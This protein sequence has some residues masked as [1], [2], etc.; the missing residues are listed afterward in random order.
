[1]IGWG[2]RKEA[3][4]VG[5]KIATVLATAGIL[6]F[7]SLSVRAEDEKN[8]ALAKALSEATVSL[9]E[10]LEAS[11]REGRP[12]SAKYEIENGA[13]QLSVYVAK[14]N[15]FAEVIVDHKGGSIKKTEPITEADDLEQAKEQQQRLAHAR[16]PLDRAVTDAV[17]DNS[18]YRAVEIEPT[19][20]RAGKPVASVTLMKGDEVKKVVEPL[21]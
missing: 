20:D 8:P 7:S 19:V 4:M 17:K 5:I 12:L 18:G 6:A 9:D 3:H 11:E 21:E 10:A 13:F 16:I 1:M 14:G 2:I 15:G